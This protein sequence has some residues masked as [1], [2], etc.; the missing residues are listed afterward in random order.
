[1]K[2]MTNDGTRFHPLRK[3]YLGIVP[4]R[5]GSKGI[6]DK[7]I[8]DVNGK[9]LLH[10]TSVPAIRAFKKGLLAELILS[11]DS[12]R[13]R[14]VGVEEGLNAP[15]LR[16]AEISD[17]KAKSIAFVKHALSFFEKKGV[18]FD[19]VILFQPTSPLRTYEDIEKSILLFDGN[20]ADSLISCYE[21]EGIRTIRLYKR[22]GHGPYG[23]PL[24][25]THSEGLRRQD[26]EPLLIRNGAMFITSIDFMN[27]EGKLVSDEP[28]I[29]EMPKARS[30]DVDTE[31][32]L[33]ELRRIMGC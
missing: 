5:G 3:R 22:K 6:K 30:L 21:D 16:P 8:A 9:P 17:D 15:F 28:L 24:D 31:G 11:T 13:I 10:Y 25:K 23:V 26:Q 4:A 12:E 33:L 2:R 29:Y 19:A 14:N 7:N 18:V 20:D 27:R 1:M 32:D